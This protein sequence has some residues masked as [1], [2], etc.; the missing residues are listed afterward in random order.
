MRKKPLSP[1]FKICEIRKFRFDCG[2]WRGVLMLAYFKSLLCH[3][4]QCG[5]YV[6]IPLVLVGHMVWRKQAEQVICK[7]MYTGLPTLI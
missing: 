2:D 7:W 1:F 6:W 3:V 4:T 5:V